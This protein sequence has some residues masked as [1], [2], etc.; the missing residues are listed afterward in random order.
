MPNKDIQSNYKI[1]NIEIHTFSLN[2]LKL[3]LENLLK[4]NNSTFLITT[5]NLD[6]LRITTVDKEFLTIC[7]KALLNLPDGYGILNIIKKNITKKLLE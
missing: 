6:F 5:F 7:Q 2:Y 1:L 4:S 3:F